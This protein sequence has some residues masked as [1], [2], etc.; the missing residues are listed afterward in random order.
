[1]GLDKLTNEIG[2][3]FSRND[4]IKKKEQSQHVS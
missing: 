1:M 3:N 4:I 2:L